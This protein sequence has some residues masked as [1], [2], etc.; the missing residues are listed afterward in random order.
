MIGKRRKE[1]FFLV[2][3]N[4]TKETLLPIIKNNIFTYCSS[5]SD[6]KDPNEEN[7]PTRIFSDCFSTYQIKDFN[8][9]GFKLYR[10]KPWCFVWERIFSCKFY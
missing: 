8:E 5:I 3:N 7:Y 2:D 9:M 6:N 4:G 1:E 10:V